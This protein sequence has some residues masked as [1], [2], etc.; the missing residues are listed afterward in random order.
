[1]QKESKKS[2]EAPK[3]KRIIEIERVYGEEGIDK[4]FVKIFTFSRLQK[5]KSYAIIDITRYK[6]ALL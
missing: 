1:M 5:A 2:Y 6:G 4:R 3:I